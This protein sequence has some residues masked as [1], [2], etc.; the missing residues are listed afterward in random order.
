MLAGKP[1]VVPL[2]FPACNESHHLFILHGNRSSMIYS[3]GRARL[4]ALL[5]GV[6]KRRQRTSGTD[7]CIISGRVHL[8]PETA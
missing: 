4:Q 6:Q 8:K 2:G 7:T 3:G 5:N 1:F